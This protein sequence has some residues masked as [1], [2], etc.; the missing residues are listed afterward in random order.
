M[1]Q[2]LQ[3]C[4]NLQQKENAVAKGLYKYFCSYKVVLVIAFMLD[5]HS[6]LAILSKQFQKKILMFSEVQSFID[7]TLAK[8][9][10]MGTADGE[11]L[12]R[13]KR[14]IQISDVGVKYKEEKLDYK[15]TMYNEFENL[16]Q[17]YIKSLKGNIKHRLRKEDGDIFSDFGKVFEPTLGSITDAEADDAMGH[18]SRFMELIRRW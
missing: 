8:L 13:M 18:L 1:H 17:R 15:V 4:Q 12:K 9:E 6:E 7:G 2:L 14:E 11:G 10:L 5:V 16:R 3:S